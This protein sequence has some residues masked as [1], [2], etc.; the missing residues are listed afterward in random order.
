MAR[1]R[2]LLPA[3][4]ISRILDLGCGAGRFSVPLAQTFACPVVGID[5]SAAML[6]Q[7]RSQQAADVVWQ[8]GAGERIG[9]AENAVDLVWMSQVFHH[10][11]APDRTFAEVQ[12]VLRPGGYLA[13]RN[14]TR[15]HRDQIAWLS[16]FPE[17][18]QVD[19]GRIPSQKAVLA[20]ISRQGL[21]SVAVETVR[22]FYAASYSEYYARIQ[23]RS[24]SALL[25]ISDAAFAAGLA[26]CK[27]WVAEQPADQP[28]YEPIDLFI[29]VTT[30]H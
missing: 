21:Q 23:Q 13:I 6:E 2:S 5:P 3:T 14:V 24:V 11:D 22:Q 25:A 8:L 29:F 20:T 15:D 7:A 4:G 10:L 19:E 27:R 18:Q 26:R 12:R 30:K 17:A 28:V 1:L 9:L 16:C